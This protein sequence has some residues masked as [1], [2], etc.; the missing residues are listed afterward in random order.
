MSGFLCFQ[1]VLL[2]EASM[3][4]NWLTVANVWYDQ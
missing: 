3:L 1:E 2:T 4:D